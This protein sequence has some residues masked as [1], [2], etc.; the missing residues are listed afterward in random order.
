M[1][2]SRLVCSASGT[3]LDSVFGF[4]T[5]ILKIPYLG[6]PM[7]GKALSL[8]WVKPNSVSGPYLDSVFGSPYLGLPLVKKTLPLGCF[9]P[10]CGSPPPYG[11]SLSLAVVVGYSPTFWFTLCGRSL[12]LMSVLPW[13]PFLIGFLNYCVRHVNVFPYWTEGQA[14]VIQRAPYRARPAILPP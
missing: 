7:V 10:S 6:L 1:C 9:K 14:V 4:H 12:S 5:W 2:L 8:G 13:I 3:Y 11:K